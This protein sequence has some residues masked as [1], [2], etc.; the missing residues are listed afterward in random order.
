VERI[1]QAGTPQQIA[2][3]TIFLAAQIHQ[4]INH[5]DLSMNA[6]HPTMKSKEIK[7]FRKATKERIAE[8]TRCLILM[9]DQSKE[10]LQQ[11]LNRQAMDLEDRLSQDLAKMPL[12]PTPHQQV[13]P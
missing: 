8:A 7:I 12:P 2:H 1:K 13:S 11:A 3:L 4:L 6:H 9:I 5:L 10:A